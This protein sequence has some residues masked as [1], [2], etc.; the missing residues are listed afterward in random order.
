MLGGKF[1]AIGTVQETFP[2]DLEHRKNPS[3]ERG[4]IICSLHRIGDKTNVNNYTTLHNA[5]TTNIKS[6][7]NVFL[8]ELSRSFV[9]KTGVR[10]GDGLPPILFNWASEKIIH[11]WQKKVSQYNISKS[12]HSTDVYKRQVL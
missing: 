8:G 1:Q 12:H 2:P 10:E 11:D 3:K 9:I 5:D 6:Q 7:I 4:T